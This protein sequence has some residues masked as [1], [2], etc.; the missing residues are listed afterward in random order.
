MSVLFGVNKELSGDR[1]NIQRNKTELKDPFRA[2]LEQIS[3]V[4]LVLK[5]FASGWPNTFC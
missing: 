3:A 2:D 1:L 5:D 4:H